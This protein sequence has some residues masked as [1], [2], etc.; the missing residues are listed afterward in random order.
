[1]KRC[2]NLAR[3]GLGMVAPNPMVGCVIV[4]DNR[5]IGEG[6]HRVFGK[7]HAEVN[8]VNA[9]EN[10]KLLPE[11]TVYVSLEPCSHH[12]KTPPCTDLLI[13]HK[14]KEVVIADTDPFHLVSGR[15][16]KKLVQNG[17]QVKTG[18]LQKDARWLNRRFYTFHLH[19]RPYIILKWAQTADGFIDKIRSPE[20]G[21]GP[22]WITDDFSRALVHKWRSEEQSIMVGTNTVLIDNPELN[23]RN[24]TGK[25]PLRVVPDF[26]DRLNHD[27]KVF[28]NKSGTIIINAKRAGKE[29]NVEYVCF[30]QEKW[31]ER[32]FLWL[33]EKNIQSIIIEGGSKLLQSFIDAGIWDEAR[34]FTG[35]SQ[36]HRGVKAPVLN[37]L[38]KFTEMIGEYKLEVCYNPKL[39]D[40]LNQ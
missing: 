15:G 25:S 31:I 39:S 38:P 4:H 35:N 24:W 22:N 19:E 17:V 28:N 30:E 40:L 32:L 34:V 11:S 10:K 3:G 29:D 21:I 6:Y 23:V 16:I 8:A 14:V 37:T 33:H 12:G 7:E 9:V 26:H 20:E 5:V 27:L 1:M 2:I 13:H 36:F 18:I